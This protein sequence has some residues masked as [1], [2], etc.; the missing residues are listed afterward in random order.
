MD[1]ISNGLCLNNEALEAT[2]VV[3]KEKCV[4]PEF[5]IELPENTDLSLATLPEIQEGI[6]NGS[7]PVHKKYGSSPISLN[8]AARVVE[9]I[10]L[11]RRHNG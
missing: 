2:V 9:S 6:H 5:G 3:S 11:L 1:G 8:D 4:L 7:I 10:R